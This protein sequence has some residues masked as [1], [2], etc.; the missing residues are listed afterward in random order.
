M[1]IGL[2]RIPT[3]RLRLPGKGRIGLLCNSAS[4]DS[5]LVSSPAVMAGLPG[6]SLERIFS[7]QHGFAGE[8]QDNM[9]ESSDGLHPALGIPMISLYGRVRE[10]EPAM[11]DGL[12]ALVIDLPDVGTRVYT[13]LITAL[14]CLRA[15]ARAGVPVVVL[16]RPNPIGGVLV[17]GPV[18]KPGFETFVGLI[19]VPL[20]HGLTPGE[21]CRFGA[22]R[23]GL[24]LSLQ[25]V[26]VEGWSRRQR[27]RDTGSHWIPPSPNLPTPEGAEVYPGMVML[28]GTNLSEGRGTTRPFELFGAPWIDPHRLGPLLGRRTDAGF[29]IPGG[30]LR[31]VAFQPTFHKYKGETV[32]GFHIHIT[33]PDRFF[34]VETVVRIL[35]SVRA[36]YPDQFMWKLPPYE[37]EEVRLPIDC[38]AGSDQLRLDLE[39]GAGPEE[40]TA[41]WETDLAD[42]LDAA[43]PFLLYPEG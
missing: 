39:R 11:L 13:F 22:D 36:Q 38:I 40:I 5:R 9:I 15:C 32:G 3:S 20:C 17:D 28:E 8:K 12:D 24:D 4:L 18:L 25:V 7:P 42:F 26:Q 1:K 27:Y 37:Y 23:L 16:D 10:P 2:D 14:Y 21:Y 30:L 35:H 43:G 19:P 33:E 29:E 31:P 41:S 6:V 34:P